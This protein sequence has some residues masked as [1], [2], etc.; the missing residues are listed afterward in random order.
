MQKITCLR[1]QN[2]FY[3]IHGKNVQVRIVTLTTNVRW[4]YDQQD[5]TIFI[6]REAAALLRRI[7]FK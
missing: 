7:E 6:N 5:A 4:I 3:V 2:Q 1:K